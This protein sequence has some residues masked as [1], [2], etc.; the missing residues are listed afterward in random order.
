MKALAYGRV[1]R[2]GVSYLRG[3]PVQAL[4]Y[5]RVLGGGGFYGRDTPVLLVRQVLRAFI[6][7]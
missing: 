7:G 5:G 1:L 4:A 3:T 6:I 2:E